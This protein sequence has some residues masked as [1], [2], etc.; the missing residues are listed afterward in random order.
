MRILF[1]RIRIGIRNTA[2]NCKNLT[3]CFVCKYCS[4]LYVINMYVI[5]RIIILWIFILNIVDANFST[6][7]RESAQIFCS[8]LQRTKLSH[9]VSLSCFIF[10]SSF[11]FSFLLF[12]FVVS[13]SFLNFSCSLSFFFP[14]FFVAY[15]LLFSF[16]FLS[17]VV[18]VIFKQPIIMPI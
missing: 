6:L 13:F 15:F 10:L 3:V 5:Q 17:F 7:G 9:P 11:L 8:E 2:E 4:M 14:S 18:A 1:I 12:F 16:S